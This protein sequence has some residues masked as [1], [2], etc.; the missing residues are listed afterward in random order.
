[1]YIPAESEHVLE[2][3]PEFKK[4]KVPSKDFLR[5]VEYYLSN[6][7]TDSEHYHTVSFR[8]CMLRIPGSVNSKNCNQVK[9]VQKWNGTT[10]VPIDLLG[11]FVFT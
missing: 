3:M 9:I 10:K 6:I 8:N 5:F 7:K 11:R 1:L 4:F 2:N